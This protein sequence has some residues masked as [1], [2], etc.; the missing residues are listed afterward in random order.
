MAWRKP[1]G[2]RALLVPV[3]VLLACG[4]ARAEDEIPTDEPARSHTT[5]SPF[6]RPWTVEFHFGAG[7]PVG[8]LG[9]MAEYLVTPA[10]SVAGGAGI[11]SGPGSRSCDQSSRDSS[12]QS[13]QRGRLSQILAE[14]ESLWTADR[15]ITGGDLR[16]RIRGIMGSM[17]KRD[18]DLRRRILLTVL[19]TGC[20]FVVR[21]IPMPGL[22]TSLLPFHVGE[23]GILPATSGYLLVEVV[24][25]LVP[26]W[27][28]LRHQA[29]GR[30]RLERAATIMT[31]V[32]ALF[33]SFGVAMWLEGLNDEAT[34]RWADVY[35]GSRLITMVL[36]A[37]GAWAYLY[38][39]RMITSS[40]VGNGFSILLVIESVLRTKWAETTLT[41]FLPGAGLSAM[42]A[43]MFVFAM[44][45][46]GRGYSPGQDVW[47]ARLPTCGLVPLTSAT[48]LPT[49]VSSLAA[50]AIFKDALSDITIGK[51]YLLVL[52]ILITAVLS[53][54]FNPREV[55]VE[56][57]KELFN[58]SKLTFG[59]VDT[60]LRRGASR[61]GMLML[62]VFGV[63]LVLASDFPL[64]F[65]LAVGIIA[66]AVAKD[67]YDEFVFR[68]RTGAV[69]VAIRLQRVCSADLAVEALRRE[70]IP[71]LARSLYHR[72][73]MHFMGPYVPL[74][75]LVPMDREEAAL[76]VV[77]T[78]DEQV[79]TEE[80]AEG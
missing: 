13:S 15:R 12:R 59:D 52:V 76:D 66:L 75:I 11:G 47:R 49:F 25:F 18:G 56:Q 62:L 79:E 54:L 37:A 3:T 42:M 22:D 43:G 27:R 31:L 67:L 38:I 41:D 64:G 61:S 26:R 70:S 30:M 24:A 29:E 39:A 35:T 23:L 36:L 1:F 20:S 17:G 72:A 7:T 8:V 80:G 63:P 32:L 21:R 9:I 5:H 58:G 16:A 2:M 48:A 77:F 60:E 65:D 4:A 33:Q 10:F 71:A 74:E 57:A 68:Y 40:G 69:T 34:G 46:V 45:S 28:P 14:R 19:L 50:F 73:L 78:L 44:S 53:Y 6:E 51:G 55:I